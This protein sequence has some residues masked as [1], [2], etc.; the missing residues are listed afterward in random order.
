MSGHPP[1]RPPLFPAWPPHSD[2]LL[3]ARMS[4]HEALTAHLAEEVGNRPDHSLMHVALE[5]ATKQFPWGKLWVFLAT[6]AAGTLAS[7]APGAFKALGLAFV[8]H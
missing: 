5:Q 6:A 8:G 4:H 1:K 7:L 2:P 3:E